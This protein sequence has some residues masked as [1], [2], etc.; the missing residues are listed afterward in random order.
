MINFF[1]ILVALFPLLVSLL[2]LLFGYL[3]AAASLRFSQ[4][5]LWRVAEVFILL[6]YLGYAGALVLINFSGDNLVAKWWF[7]GWLGVALAWFLLF[8]S[9]VIFKF[10]WWMQAVGYGLFFNSLLIILAVAMLTVIPILSVDSKEF[11][12]AWLQLLII[13]FGFLGLVK[14]L[15]LLRLNAEIVTA[16]IGALGVCLISIYAAGGYLAW[17]QD[18]FQTGLLTYCIALLGVMLIVFA[19]LAKNISLTASKHEQI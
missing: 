6:L 15:V 16:V 17:R 2:L 12:A 11:K 4:H 10:N 19:L 14:S 18:S 3:N 9:L 7:G 13:S 5:S 8:F 1:Y